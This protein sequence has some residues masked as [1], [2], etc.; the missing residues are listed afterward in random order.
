M[1][2]AVIDTLN[3]EQMRSLLM[4][5][6]SLAGTPAVETLASMEDIRNGRN[7]SGP[8]SSVAELMEALNAD[9]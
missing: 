2:N 3:E 8:F 9:D 5:L 1:L 7:M 4:F 6:S